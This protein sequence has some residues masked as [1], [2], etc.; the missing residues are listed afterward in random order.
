MIKEIVLD[1]GHHKSDFMIRFG[2]CSR[3]WPIMSHSCKFLEECFP[4]RLQLAMYVKRGEYAMFERSR[5]FV[6]GKLWA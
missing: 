1:S 3:R 4:D 2:R 5:D 6:K